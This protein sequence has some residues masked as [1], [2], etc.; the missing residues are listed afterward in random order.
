MSWG[1][2]RGLQIAESQISDNVKEEYLMKQLK[3]RVLSMLVLAA[4][5]VPMVALV[6]FAGS[7][8]GV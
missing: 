5:L 6:A 2:A 4:I 3:R 1:W 8:A 7:R